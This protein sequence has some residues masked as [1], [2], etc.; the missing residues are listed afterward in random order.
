MG[1]PH[2]RLTALDASFL[3]LEHEG[4][5]MH[6]GAVSTFEAP[7]LLDRRGHVRIRAIRR[8]LAARLDLVPRF[9]QVVREVPFGAGLPV[10]ADDPDFDIANHVKV[11]RLSRPGDERGL[12][13]LA[14]ELH[15]PLLDR[16]R[17]LWE[18]WFVEGLDG[19]RIAQVEKVHHAMIDGV[20]GVDVASVLLDLAPTRARSVPPPWTPRLAPPAARRFADA[21]L[22]RS[23]APLV[24]LRTATRGITRPG[25]WFPTTAGT[26]RDVARALATTGIAP[27]T[28]LNS[29]VG[30]AR[31]LVVIRQ[32]LAEVKAAGRPHGASVNDVVLC[33]VSE[34]LRALLAGRG[35]LHHG[36]SLTA[37]VPVSLRA[38]SEHLQL[39]N[40]VG[41]IF[42]PL[43]VG[44][45]DPFVR[46][47]AISGALARAKAR[48]D[49]AAANRVL[50]AADLL[51]PVLVGAVA[52]L[53]HR[54]P[55]VNLVVTNVPGPPVPLYAM[56]ARMLETFP[57]VPLAGNLTLGVAILSYDGQLNLGVHADPEACPDLDVFVAGVERGFALLAV[58]AE[59]DVG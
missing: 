37:L 41:A 27:R 48:R 40:R 7:P 43:P 26:V 49:A 58:P 18:L 22:D 15:R 59:V 52:Q 54:Q 24:A 25:S 6:V 2:D 12:L 16:T 13:D 35:E 8:E 19:G 1:R 31:R 42:A 28:S 23:A 38:E 20:S 32:Q 11:V 45:A 47:R 53:V 56:G 3:H 30:T 10:W 5:P 14:V 34:G 44:T 33:A 17:P 21:L 36:L 46:L 39:G 57:L 9:R 4:T 50:G 51:P 29:S 55:F